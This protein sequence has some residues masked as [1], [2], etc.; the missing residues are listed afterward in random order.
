MT[1]QPGAALPGAAIVP[2][3]ERG[4][5]AI[6]EKVVAR[7]AA[8]AAKEALA[9]HITSAAQAK[10]A[11]PQASA[12]IG[13]GSARLRLTVD[14]P[15][16]AD[17]ATTSRQVQHYISERVAHLTGMRVTE[18][19]LAIEHLVSADGQEHRRVQ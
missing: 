3:A 14:L 9:A 2:P 15:Y 6:P 19:A 17:L 5:T 18:V 1:T 7:I 12:T 4:A 11:A 8:R 16:P 10:L 13:S